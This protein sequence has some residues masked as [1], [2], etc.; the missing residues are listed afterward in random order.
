MLST[1]ASHHKNLGVCVCC[2][3]WGGGGGNA[4]IFLNFNLQ[5]GLY[6]YRTYHL[7]GWGNTAS[8]IKVV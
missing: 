6:I 8:K 1:R 5:K 2:G 3:G 7:G 4:L